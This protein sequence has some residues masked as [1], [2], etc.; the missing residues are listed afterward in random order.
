[1]KIFI[2]FSKHKKR[3]SRPTNGTYDVFGSKLFMKFKRAYSN[4]A[5]NNNETR[6]R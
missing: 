6:A 5:V 2:H 3:K 1:M 4:D